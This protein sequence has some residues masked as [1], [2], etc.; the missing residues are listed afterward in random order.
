MK[1]YHIEEISAQEDFRIY[2]FVRHIRREASICMGESPFPGVASYTRVSKE[3]QVIY[4]PD[5]NGENKV[6]K[7]CGDIEANELI[8]IMNNVMDERD[9]WKALAESK[10]ELIERIRLD[11]I[12][13]PEIEKLEPVEEKKSRWAIL[14]IMDH[15]GINNQ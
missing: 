12:K 14:D 8:S 13:E 4:I 15:G 1:F 3:I 7:I 11:N 10:A 5:P 6:L 2:D 9:M